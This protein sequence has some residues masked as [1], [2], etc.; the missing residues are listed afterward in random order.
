[1]LTSGRVWRAALAMLI[2]GLVLARP[3]AAQ[4][5]Q[6]ES[7]TLTAAPPKVALDG[8]TALQLRGR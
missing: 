3:A 1:V 8:T 4:G 6:L 7:V 5:P 2:A